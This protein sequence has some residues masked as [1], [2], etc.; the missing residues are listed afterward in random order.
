MRSWPNLSHILPNA[1]LPHAVVL[2]LPFQ[3]VV[4]CQITLAVVVSSGS[5]TRHGRNR[6]CE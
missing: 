1:L 2:H 6:V 3:A 5:L 4:L